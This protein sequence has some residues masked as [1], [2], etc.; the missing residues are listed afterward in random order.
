[1]PLIS[2]GSALVAEKQVSNDPSVSSHMCDGES[3]NAASRAD[4]AY[5]NATVMSVEKPTT[6]LK[7][8]DSREVC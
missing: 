6:P 1:M 7:N 4:A 2:H 5:S 3:Y 8:L